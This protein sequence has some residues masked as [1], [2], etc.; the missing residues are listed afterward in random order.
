MAPPP[1]PPTTLAPELVAALAPQLARAL[2]EL[3][4]GAVELVVHDG[5]VVQIERR[6][7]LRLAADPEPGEAS[8]T[9][10]S[11]PSRPRPDCRSSR[12]EISTGDSA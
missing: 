4:F 2:A 10:P 9:S 12:Q 5:R 7:R 1:L 8:R 11:V 3:R 6:D